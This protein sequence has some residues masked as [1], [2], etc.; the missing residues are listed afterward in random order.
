MITYLFFDFNKQLTE[1]S[2]I[3]GRVVPSDH[4]TWWQFGQC[5][6]CGRAELLRNEIGKNKMFLI[7]RN[8]LKPRYLVFWWILW[9]FL[10]KF[11]DE[12]FSMNFFRQIFFSTNFF[13]EVISDQ[14][15]YDLI[16]SLSYNQKYART[17]LSSSTH[18]HI[19]ND[20]KKKNL[21]LCLKNMYVLNW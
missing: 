9:I 20:E 21:R 5:F 18:F 4:I 19:W 16:F 1:C 11:F 17:N 7:H 13:D 3:C 8:V 6:V 15:T 12:Y 10:R 2:M 14:S